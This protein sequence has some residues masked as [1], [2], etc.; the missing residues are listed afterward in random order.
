[1]NPKN[2][3][4]SPSC[5]DCGATND[6]GAS[7][8]W[9][10]QRRDWRRSSRGPMPMKPEPSPTS[11]HRSPLVALKLGLVVIGVFLIAPVLGMAVY[12]LYALGDWLV[13]VPLIFVAPAW[14]GAVVSARRRRKRGLPTSIARKLAWIAV[15]TIT[16]PIVLVMA[17]VITV[18]LVCQFTGPPSFH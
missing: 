7:E 6:P 3:E 14:F 17:L 12:L 4:S 16:I 1:M 15:L 8:C 10:C 9:L 13:F 11:G 18:G 2:P 5:W